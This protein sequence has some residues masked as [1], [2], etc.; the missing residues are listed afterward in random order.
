MPYRFLLIIAALCLLLAGCKQPP[1]PPEPTLTPVSTAGFPGVTPY[2][3][4][5][6]K[7]SI[8]FP[9]GWQA[10][11]AMQNGTGVTAKGP[12]SSAQEKTPPIALVTADQ[13][14]LLGE[15]NRDQQLKDVQDQDI[16]DWKSVYSDLQI[17]K[18]EAISIGTLQGRRAN[19][20]FTIKGDPVT[21]DYYVIING[22]TAYKIQLMVDTSAYPQVQP[23]FEKIAGSFQA[24]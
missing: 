23:D 7:F 12:R 18:E 22:Q 16:N 2:T 11:A 20:T 5:A 4:T 19:Y 3:D 21:S 8:Q 13:V 24:Q 10:P 14:K 15:G 1:P 17:T 9:S 6:N